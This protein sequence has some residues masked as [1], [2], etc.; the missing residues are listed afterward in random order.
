MKR[1]EILREGKINFT[2]RSFKAFFAI[3][4]MLALGTAILA[5]NPQPSDAQ[6]DRKQKIIKHK[7]KKKRIDLRKKTAKLYKMMK[8]KK[9]K[10]GKHLIFTTKYGIKCYRIIKD[11]TIT[12]LVFFNNAGKKLRARIIHGIQEEEELGEQ[13]TAPGEE[14]SGIDCHEGTH[15]VTIIVCDEDELGNEIP[16]TCVELTDCVPD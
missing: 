8:M 7:I 11:G 14:E 13:Q 6:K 10:D 16:E 4:I 9:L 2:I 5:A 3:L 12:T 15:S 1:S